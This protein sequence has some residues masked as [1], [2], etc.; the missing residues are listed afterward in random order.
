MS[1]KIRNERNELTNYYSGE[2]IVYVKG[3]FSPVLPMHTDI[4]THK[5]RVWH[6]AQYDACKR[7]RHIDH[8]YLETDKC[9]AY[10]HDDDVIAFRSPNYVLCNFYEAKFFVYNSYFTSVEQA[11]QWR[12][13]K[14]IGQ[15]A[16]AL[17]ISK[18]KTPGRAKQIANRVP[19]NLL[20]DWHVIKCDV[21][22]ELLIAK[23]EQCSKFRS[24]LLKTEGKR[25]IEA[26]NDMYWASGL[27]PY[28]STTTKPECFP[29]KNWLGRI[30]EDIRDERRQ[31]TS[32]SSM[33]TSDST[34]TLI[35]E[36]FRSTTDQPPVSTTAQPPRVD[37]CS[38]TCVD[39]CSTPR[40]DYCSTPCVDYCSAPR[41]DRCSA[42]RV[43]HCSAPRVD[44]C[45]VTCVDHC[46]TSRVDHCSSP[47][48]DHCSAPVSTT[49][50]PPCRPL[51]SHLC[52]PLLNSR[53]RPL[54]NPLCRPLLCPPW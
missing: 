30:L 45:S 21:M 53:Y 34:N 43:D 40:V 14:H 22:R 12:K 11:Y 27:P 3:D 54:L 23:V 10:L 29:G 39:H 33:D 49:A 6:S 9:N 18:S 4:G 31:S 16:Y 50:Q 26:T 15:E 37:H 46:S 35:E 38:V 17:E 5:I 32:S 48:V 7:C 36:A 42:S 20:K 24:I 41:V 51:L 19:G 1:G 47:R 8:G 2:R 28:L 13:M 44:P 52:R 25:L